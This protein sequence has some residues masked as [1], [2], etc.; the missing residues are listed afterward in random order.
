MKLA[1]APVAGPGEI[2]GELG[3]DA[4]GVGTEHEDA[5]G[6]EDGFLDVVG[7]DEHRLGGEVGAAPQLEELAAEVL[8]GEDVEGGERLVHEERVGFDDERAGEADALAHAA[9]ELL[10]VRGLEAVEADEVDDPFGVGRGGWSRG[11]RG[12]R[13]RARRSGAR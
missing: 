10:G 9:R 12:L 7:D 1:V 2:D 4:A 11:R 13:V 3:A 5:V 6:E 8:G